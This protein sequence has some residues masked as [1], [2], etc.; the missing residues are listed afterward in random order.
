MLTSSRSGGITPVSRPKTYYPPPKRETSAAALSSPNYD[1]ATFSAPAEGSGFQA[2]MEVVSRLA[3]EVRT[4]TT[5]GDIQDLRQ[6]VSSGT[7]TPDPMSIAAR[8]LF[9]AED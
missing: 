5:T 8:M 6:A 2:Q 4:A 3:Y 1:S 7:Y 9:I